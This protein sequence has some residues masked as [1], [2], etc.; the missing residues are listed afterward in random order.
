MSADFLEDMVAAATDRV[1]QAWPERAQRPPAATSRQRGGLRDALLAAAD[2]DLGV[3]AEVKRASPSRGAIDPGL[4]A[5]AQARAYEAAGA[6]AVSVLTEPTRFAGSLDDLAAVTAAVSLPVLRKDF[7]VD[8]RQ[9]WEAAER[10]ASAVLLIVDAL[11]GAR[12]RLLLEEAD[13]CG[14]D[15]LVEAH[16]EIGVDRALEAGATLIGANTRDL[17][18]LAVDAAV[19]ERVADRLGDRLGAGVVL[20]AESGISGATDARRAARAGARAVLVG[21]ALVR[22]PRAALPSLIAEL[23]GR[24][25]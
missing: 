1:M 2:G 12:L 22:A 20:V 13:A 24:W 18:T 14:L 8:P 6:D 19:V 5:S 23:K 11:P 16:D 25:S 10:D 7:I 3:I 9:V 15:A 21:E 17:R 4:V